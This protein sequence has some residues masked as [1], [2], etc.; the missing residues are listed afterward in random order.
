MTTINITAQDTA[1]TVRQIQEVIG[2]TISGRWGEYVL[3][4]S[5]QMAKGSIRFLTFE[6]GGSLLEYNITFFNEIML[7]MDTSEFNPIHFTYISNGYCYHRFE[8]E[9]ANRKLE[10]L[11]PIIITSKDGGYN[12]GYFPKDEKLHITLVQVS[13]I[14]FLKKRLNDAS[15]LNQNLYR[16]FHDEHHEHVF[17]YFGSYNLK[18]AQLV[19]S[20][21]D[22]KQSGMMRILLIEGIVYQILALHLEHHSKDMQKSKRNTNLTKRELLAVRRISKYILKDVSKDQ[23]V[24]NLALKCGLNHTKLQEG[25]KHLFSRTVTEYIRHVRLE[26]ARDLMDTTDLNITQIVYAIGFSSRSYFS[27]IFKRKYGIRPSDYLKK[28]VMRT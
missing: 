7:V 20:L 1:G 21:S 2:G 25:F 23:N 26:E 12:Y 10:A 18:L 5:S 8:K 24:D 4:V 17:S 9:D 16:V 27:K 6:W 11:R 22:I 13:R 14:K 15:V 19:K 28:Q 3:N